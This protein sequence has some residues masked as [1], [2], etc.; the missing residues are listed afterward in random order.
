MKRILTSILLLFVAIIG[1]AQENNQKQLQITYENY[2]EKL[3]NVKD[4][5]INLICTHDV[6]LSTEVDLWQNI[7]IT[8]NRNTG[9]STTDNSMKTIV[10]H[11]FKDYRTNAIYY[12]DKQLFPCDLKEQLNLFQWKI[13]TKQKRILGYKCTKATAH[14]R[15]RDY[16]AWF[17]TEIPFKVAPWKFHGLPGVVLKARSTND[18]IGMEAIKLKITKGREPKNPFKGKKFLTYD[19]FERI[20]KQEYAE[21]IEQLKTNCA[22]FGQDFYEPQF[23]RPEIIVEKNK[24][25]WKEYSKSLNK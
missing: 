8:M 14:Y 6:C 1:S 12:H 7:G 19:E 25:T 20:Y 18:Y 3:S 13:G 11:V 23:P 24:M 15:G 5:K 9:E 4:A 17:T 22:R 16:E 2:T 10:N 21:G